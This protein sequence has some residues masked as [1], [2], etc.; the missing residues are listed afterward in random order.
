MGYLH[1]DN[2]YKNQDILLFKE[3]YALEKIH[4]TSA[5]VRWKE[6][7]VRFFSGGES[8]NKYIALF[9]EK[10]LFDKFDEIFGKETHVIVH[11]EAYGGKQQGMKL[12][13]GEDLKF[14]VF[15]V[16]VDDCWLDV[17]NAEDVAKKLGLEFVSYKRILSRLQYI[18]AQ[19]DKHSVQ[20]ERNGCGN[21]KLREG[22]V[23]RPL[24]EVTKNNGSRVISKHKRDEFKETATKREVSPEKLKILKEAD[25]IAKEWVTHMRLMHILDKADFDMKIENTGKVIKLMIED[26]HRE[27]KDE[28]V[29]NATTDKS[30][31]KTTALLYKKHLGSLV[32]EK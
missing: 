10:N 21:D 12:T 2:L 32:K 25:T 9:D 5:N 23:L 20:A 17:P 8:Y 22:I 24:I 16:K 13:Y 3:C 7:S 1:I 29:I 15:D 30:I 31:G 4:G 26:I 14:V 18:D 19:R 6:G 11:G 27:A 28:I